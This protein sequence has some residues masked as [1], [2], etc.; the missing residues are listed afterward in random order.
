MRKIGKWEYPYK[1]W[2]EDFLD[3]HVYSDDF[4]EGIAKKYHISDQIA[5]KECL[6][7][8][9]KFYVGDEAYY[10][11]TGNS[12]SAL[13]DEVRKIRKALDDLDNRLSRLSLEAYEAYVAEF[14]STYPEDCGTPSFYSER[15]FNAEF[16]GEIK[17]S[18]EQFYGGYDG[19]DTFNESIKSL[20]E[21]GETFQEASDE[22]LKNLA[23]H[24][25]LKD[26]SGHQ[27]KPLSIYVESMSEFWLSC[28]KGPIKVSR[29]AAEKEEKDRKVLYAGDFLDFLMEC[30][31]PIKFHNQA[32]ASAGAK[33][34]LRGS[35]AAILKPRK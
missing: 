24:A 28:G 4:I 33:Y 25:P 14:S 31:E 21:I 35:I 10:G 23:F 12:T 3:D 32:G 26:G 29:Y 16:F 22:I 17:P 7:R 2:P 11:D 6:I 9:A 19:F 20:K 30:L 8:S 15:R 18:L 5:L 13:K 27:K 1:V 34:K